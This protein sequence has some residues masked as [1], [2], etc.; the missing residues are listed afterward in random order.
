MT[1]AKATFSSWLAITNLV[2]ILAGLVI[3]SFPNLIILG[4]FLFILPGFLM[5]LLPSAA[6]YLT[7]FSIGWFALQRVHAGL[8]LVAGLAA[9]AAFGFWI[10]DTL[11]RATVDNLDAIPRDRELSAPIGNVR[12]VALETSAQY[13]SNA[14]GDLCQ[15]LLFNGEVERV[16]VLPPTGQRP[17]SRRAPIREQRVY[18]VEKSGSC[19]QSENSRPA[20]HPWLDNLDGQ[21]IERA[22]LTRIAAGECLLSES[23]TE[24]RPDLTLRWVE[25]RENHSSKD[26]LRLEPKPVSAVGLEILDSSG[27]I[28]ARKLQRTARL[29][30]VPLFLEPISSGGGN[31]GFLGWEWSK[32]GSYAEPLKKAELLE[33]FTSFDLDPPHGASDSALRKQ[34]DAM[35]D[36]P[37][38]PSTH[39]AFALL[40]PYFREL[41]SES[42][43][44]EDIGR[45]IRIVR[46][47]RITKFYSL[48]STIARNTQLAPKLKDAMLDRLQALSTTDSR[49]HE[50]LERFASELPKGSF[51]V[52]DPRVEALLANP[53]KR[54]LSPNLVLRQID[55]GSSA[56]PLFIRFLREAWTPPYRDGDFSK[57]TEA[58][59]RGLCK[60]GRSASAHLPQLQSMAREGIVPKYTQEGLMWR[61][62]LV[63]LGVDAASFTPLYKRKNPEEYKRELNDYVKR[64]CAG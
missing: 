62:M 6:I 26:R 44:G 29:Y 18:R 58:S 2:L 63:S 10:P 40:N 30:K 19:P 20:S 45:L 42:L 27:R 21:K 14:C 48:P 56:A 36:D 15:I 3:Y 51:A 39:A 25:D 31:I 13:G 11:N 17:H 59:M 50:D 12:S 34:I 22:V 8:G 4:F 46:D 41:N 23:I 64:H 55:R 57:L 49:T 16:F 47:P 54:R 37:S 1:S 32:R 52:P 7:L 28:I 61:A 5:G 24:A 35:L 38:L 43:S 60:L 53:L 33:R 9:M